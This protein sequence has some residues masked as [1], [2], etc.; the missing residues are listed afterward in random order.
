M[1]PQ[2]DKGSEAY[3]KAVRSTK[4]RYVNEDFVKIRADYIGGE[5]VMFDFYQLRDWEVSYTG[6][7]TFSCHRLDFNFMLLSE[8]EKTMERGH[9]GDYIVLDLEGYT[10]KRITLQEKRSLLGR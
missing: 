10:L 3:G 5:S 6:N 9:P 7:L 2:L 8:D 4:I 1:N